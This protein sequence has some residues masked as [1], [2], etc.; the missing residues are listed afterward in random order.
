M[1]N[2]WSEKL[3][4]QNYES[5]TKYLP[6][7]IAKVQILLWLKR[8]NYQWHSTHLHPESNSFLFYFDLHSISILD[9]LNDLKKLA[10]YKNIP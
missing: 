1:L 6:W 7:N 10:Q 3:S 5:L 8:M 4:A 2:R 9:H